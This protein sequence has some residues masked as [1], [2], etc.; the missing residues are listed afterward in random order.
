VVDGRVV[1]V[2][3]AVVVVANVESYGEWL[4]LTPHAS[5]V[6]GLFDVFVMR[7]RSH[8]DVFVELLQRHLGMPGARATRLYRGRRIR[9]SGRR[10]SRDELTIL[11]RRLPVV[12]TPE[13]AASLRRGTR[14]AR[15]LADPAGSIP[16]ARMVPMIQRRPSPRTRCPW[17]PRRA[18]SLVS[19]QA[20]T[21]NFVSSR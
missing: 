17:P 11:R 21:P 18:A 6:D 19:G 15:G 13:T 20:R 3:A 8:R 9:V 16:L 5:P 10:A 2:D 7:G 1:A 12:V 4:P 14:S